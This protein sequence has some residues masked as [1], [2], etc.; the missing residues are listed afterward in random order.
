LSRE[1]KS[2]DY[3]PDKCEFKHQHGRQ[4]CRNCSFHNFTTIY[5]SKHSDFCESCKELKCEL[6]KKTRDELKSAQL[7]IDLLV[8]E[9]NFAAAS[10]GAST[11]RYQCKCNDTDLSSDESNRAGINNWT[12]VKKSYSD[13]NRH[14]STRQSNNLREQFNKE[15]T[16]PSCDLRF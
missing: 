1:H 16:N 2:E 8:R 7:I 3:T 5:Q 4:Y 11:N 13:N 15:V 14:K 6:Q 12:P 9:I 10:T